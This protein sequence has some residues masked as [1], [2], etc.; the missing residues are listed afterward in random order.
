MYFYILYMNKNDQFF[1][2]C[3]KT[4][5]K[6]V[7]KSNKLKSDMPIILPWVQLNIL[8]NLTSRGFYHVKI[9]RS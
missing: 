9:I 3:A 5:L 8:I 7:T 6:F 1:G 2:F 4:I